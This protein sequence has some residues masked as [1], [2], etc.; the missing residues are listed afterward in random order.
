M[1]RRAVRLAVFGHYMRGAGGWRVVAPMLLL[2][3]GEQLLE[4]GSAVWLAAWSQRGLRS[5][6]DAA[7]TEAAELQ[8]LY[9]YLALSLA[10]G[11]VTLL[12][13]MIAA[14]AGWRASRALHRQLYA[15]V[16]GGRQAWFDANPTGRVLNR[17]TRDTEKIDENV[18]PNSLAP[19]TPTIPPTLSPQPEGPPSPWPQP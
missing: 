2:F 8:P 1:A 9:I 6:S 18:P 11:G 10:Q 5:G 13:C 16:L 15:A 17:F 12:M 14:Y 19:R 7:A 3:V 4:R